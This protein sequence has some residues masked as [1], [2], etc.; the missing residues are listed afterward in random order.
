MLRVPHRTV[1]QQLFQLVFSSL[2]WKA[3]LHVLRKLPAKARLPTST[4][5]KAEYAPH[6][7]LLLVVLVIVILA[8]PLE[9][10]L[11]V[12]VLV[13]GLVMAF[14]LIPVPMQMA[15]TRWT[16]LLPT[17]LTSKLWSNLALCQPKCQNS[18][19]AIVFLS[20]VSHR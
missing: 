12:Q 16:W 9:V 1:L 3:F 7:C 4:L 15:F 8:L 14:H 18:P 13:P 2:P 10:L 6:H 17:T 20:A 19:S 5:P 11:S